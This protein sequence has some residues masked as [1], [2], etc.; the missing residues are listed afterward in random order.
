MRLPCDLAATSGLPEA[1]GTFRNSLA[2]PV[3]K[4]ALSGVNNRQ[5]IIPSGF[6][7]RNGDVIVSAP[8]GKPN[9]L[10]LMSDQHSKHLLGCQ[11]ND[12]VRT[13][14]LD[15]LAAAGM[16]FTSAYCPAPLCVPGR[17]SF[18]T[19]LTPSRNR[20]WNNYHAL[21]SGIP[22]WAHVLGAAGY[23]TSLIGRMHFVGPDQ[24]HGFMRRPLGEYGACHPGAP[25]RGGP[26]WTKYSSASTG[27]R[28]EAVEI[29]GTGTTAYQWFDEQVTKAACRYLREK[30]ED[31]ADRPF[32]AVV[33]FLLPH[34]PYIAPKE[35]FDYYYSRVDIPPVEE[36]RP[37]TIERHLRYRG[38]VPNLSEER[39]RLARAAYF[40]LCEQ[41]DGL[42]GRILD[43]LEE[44]GLAENTMVVYCSDHG[45][46]AGEHGCWTKSNYY[47]ASAGVP[48][49]VRWPGET[50]G[51]AV[52]AAVC[53]LMD[54]G[55]T[56]AEA[57]GVVD[58]GASPVKAAAPHRIARAGAPAPTS[59]AEAAG[60]E[61]TYESDGNSLVPL[62]RGKGEGWRDET[63]CELVDYEGGGEHPNL[64]S[65]MVRSGKW[66]LWR[67]GDSEKLPPALFN[68][69]EDPGELDDLGQ[70]PRFAAVREEL[71]GK[72]M[73]G[74]DPDAASRATEEARKWTGALAA[75]G[76][77]VQPESPDLLPAP[78]PEIEDDVELL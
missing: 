45:E 60:V 78:P 16:R 77:A 63:F 70:D 1:P 18:M 22:T 62:L 7:P 67:F 55:P 49:I 19:S 5:R 11:G 33:G 6:A 27:Q 25:G 52:S 72:I 53:N 40:A 3:D 64:P 9:I 8:G 21:S 2:A 35:L 23:E 57:A 28:R 50:P 44:T 32:A 46:S 15:R 13:P 34:C 37:P 24:R 14:H 56:F 74:W 71:L 39:V 26:L 42:I 4:S 61:F 17:M 47:E 29:V 65:R 12:I 54:L 31:Q 38:F 73:N 58:T 69:E 76:R 51:G 48:L 30:S 75:W 59:F 36:S 41:L 66:K 10:V 68:L 20:V 43:R